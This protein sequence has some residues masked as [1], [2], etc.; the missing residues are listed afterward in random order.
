M[1][2]VETDTLQFCRG[3]RRLVGASVEV[4]V[5]AEGRVVAVSVD[6]E[7]PPV[8]ELHEVVKV[9]LLAAVAAVSSSS[10]G[11]E[12][13]T[14]VPA[15][16]LANA[17]E[18]ITAVVLQ[19]LGEE[20]GA[21]LDVVVN[22]R[23]VAA[24]GIATL[25]TRELHQASLTG[26]TDGSGVAATLLHGEGSKNDG[27]DSDLSTILLEFTNVRLAG[28]KSRVRGPC[29]GRQF[30]SD[31]VVNRDIWRVPTGTVDTAVQ[32]VDASVRASSSRDLLN[33]TAGTAGSTRSD[34]DETADNT[35]SGLTT[36]EVV[37]S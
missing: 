27:G 2:S 13:Q 26:T 34:L 11:I 9:V 3:E 1:I 35:P 25:V 12:G 28:S 29:N 30:L 33:S 14:L 21:R 17:L 15:V 8:Q 6:V 7:D 18:Q 10:S 19:R 24:G 32:E 31:N 22:V 20:L 16:V 4:E 36:A 23:A 37:T 5:L